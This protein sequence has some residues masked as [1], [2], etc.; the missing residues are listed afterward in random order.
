MLDLLPITARD[1][2]GRPGGYPEPGPFSSRWDGFYDT[3]KYRYSTLYVNDPSPIP[4]IRVMCQQDTR[5]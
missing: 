2:G 4:S 5:P 1:R 3:C